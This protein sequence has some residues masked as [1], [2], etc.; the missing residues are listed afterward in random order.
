M[1]LGDGGRDEPQSEHGDEHPPSLERL[2]EE[3]KQRRR[4]VDRGHGGVADAD[5]PSE[6]P[7]TDD[8][9]PF[10]FPTSDERDG[11]YG[12]DPKTEAI[13]ELVGDAANVLLLGPLLGPAD[14]D[15]CTSMTTALAGDT[16]N[17]LLVTLTES[18][19]DRLTVFQGYLDRFPERTVVLNVGD[20]TRSGTTETV[21]V[22]DGG[23]VRIQ[24]ISDPTD[25]MRIGIATSRLLSEWDDSGGTTAVCFHSLTALLQYADDPKIVFRFVHTLLG[26]L[27]SAGARA[28]FHMDSNA[29]DGQTIGT[30]R[31]IFDEVL[32]FEEDGTV[33]V[34]R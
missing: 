12:V 23:T 6:P 31:P 19:D 2:V 21:S 32:A 3:V 20:S 16:D 7:T 11:P 1:N 17:L 27:E 24:T 13:I 14:Y 29:H 18:P 34:D 22:G 30:F 8:P 33:S 25:L 9:A 5:P 26:R 10:E 15:L 28:H 4:G